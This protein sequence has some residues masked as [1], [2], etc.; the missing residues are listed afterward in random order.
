[1]TARLTA[2]SEIDAWCTR[3]RLDLG[4]RIVAMVGTTPKRVVCL[5]CDSQHNYRAPKVAGARPTRA[6]APR[7]S[8]TGARAKSSV[9][10]QRATWDER[11]AGHEL[12]AFTKYSTDGTYVLDELVLHKKFGP[13]FVLEV[14]SPSKVS[15]MFQDGPRT[16]A[17]A[18]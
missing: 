14:L 8:K 10:A 17:M 15:V 2:G 5:T 7:A 16:L 9:T 3:C 13:G 18:L 1:M 12:S 11:T 6:S 4:H